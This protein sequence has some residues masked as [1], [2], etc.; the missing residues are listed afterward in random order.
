MPITPK[1][2]TPPWEEIDQA[3]LRQF[4]DTVTGKRLLQQLFWRRP[5]A[6]DKSDVTK[7]AMQSCVAEG[8][9]QW[10]EELDFLTKPE[11]KKIPQNNAAATAKALAEPK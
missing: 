3:N 9:E 1:T 2:G 7:R 11:S 4:L 6:R 8:Y 5:K 10:F